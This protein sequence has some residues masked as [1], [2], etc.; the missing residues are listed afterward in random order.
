MQRCIIG[1]RDPEEMGYWPLTNGDNSRIKRG[2][3]KCRLKVKSLYS[4]NAKLTHEF[5]KHAS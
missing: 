5:V 3:A 4:D 1:K 2:I